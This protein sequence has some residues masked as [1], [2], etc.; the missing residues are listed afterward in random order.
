MNHE[1]T[2][3]IV[4]SE[5]THFPPPLSPSYR[6]SLAATDIWSAALPELMSG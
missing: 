3:V 2:A 6:E 4:V 1:T 5:R